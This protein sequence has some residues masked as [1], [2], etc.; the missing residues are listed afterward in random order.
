VHIGIDVGGTNTDAVLM[1]HHEVLAAVKRP[2]TGDV[3]SGIRAALAALRDSPRFDAAAIDAVMLGTTHFTNAVVSMTGLTPTA[4]VRLSLPSSSGVPPLVDWPEA[5]ADVLGRHVYQ[6][7]GGYEFDGRQIA[8]PD[9]AELAKVARDIAAKRITAIAITGVFSPLKADHELFARD[10]LLKAVPGARISMSHEIGR[11]GLIE[12]ENATVINAA[13]LDLAERT[14]EAF[15]DALAH[16]GIDAPLYL[17]QN[18]GTLMNVEF[19][20]RFPVTTFSSGP[21]NSMRGAALLSG[22]KDCVV[23]DI[24]GTTADIGVLVGGFPR[25]ATTHVDISG[26]RTNFRMPDLLPMG[27]GGGSLVDLETASV[28]PK[29]VGYRLAS[30][31]LVFGGSTLTATDL[32]VAAGIAKIGD[33]N[34]VA[35]LDRS[36]VQAALDSIKQR[37]AA[38]VDMMRTSRDP[39]P[40]VLVG[41]GSVLIDGEL[42]GLGPVVRPRHADCAN[43]VGAAIAQIGAEVDKV[44]TLEGKDRTAEL[45]L[46]ADEAKAMV[47]ASGAVAS[48]IEIVE[49]DEV[50]I[51]Y[52]PGDCVRVRVKAVGDLAMGS[53]QAGV[54]A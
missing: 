34:N 20:K 47:L 16:S 18:D 54:R 15:K 53:G 23:I 43:A 28:G 50:P 40:V 37:I 19:A 11:V 24:G 46:I 45:G 44:L 5:L 4:V 31:A 13:L 48:S 29:S 36:K 25:Q 26:V 9:E 42:P 30:E 52:L 3:L 22:L 21:T 33:V 41:G 39:V 35:A 7:R 10:C 49:M 38:A 2:T 12:R 1:Q 8:A 51:A 27:I 32:A 17:S 14:T 6:V